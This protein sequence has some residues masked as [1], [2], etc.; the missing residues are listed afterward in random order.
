MLA[1]TRTRSYEDLRLHVAVGVMLFGLSRIR[2]YERVCRS[3]KAV[4]LTVVWDNVV[5]HNVCVSITLA[6]DLLQF[7]INFYRK[8]P[9]LVHTF[10]DH[11]ATVIKKNMV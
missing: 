9:N 8:F 2:V 7:S 3:G 1:G 6:R 5:Q 4:R 10:I 11:P